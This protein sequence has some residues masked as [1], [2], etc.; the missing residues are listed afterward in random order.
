[1][2]KKY[3]SQKDI[4]NFVYPNHTLSEYDI[5]L[6]QDI[7][8]N[9]VYGS[10]SSFNAY[11]SGGN[12]VISF[13]YQW[14]L[15]NAEPFI[16]GNGQ[17][18]ILSVHMMAPNTTYFKPWRLVDFVQTT[19]VNTTTKTGTF[20]ATVTPGQFQV[21]SLNEGV[22][23]FEIRMI[24]HRA[25]YPICVSQSVVNVTPTPTPSQVAQYPC[26]CYDI[27]VTGTTLGE[28]QAIASIS[29][30]NCYGVL[31]T[32]SYTIGPATYQL[33]IERLGG[34]IQ[35]FSASGIDESYITGVGNGACVAG[36]CPTTGVTST[37]TPT[38]T[39][40]PTVTHTPGLSPTPT[41]TVTSS[42]SLNFYPLTLR[43]V[44][45]D[46]RTGSLTVYQSSDN[47]TFEQSAQIIVSGNTTTNQ[48]FNGTP[49]YYYYFVVAKT[50]GPAA[51]L[52]AYVDAIPDLTPSVDGAWCDDAT[53]L[54][55]DVFQLP[56]PA[57]STTSF[58][59]YGSVTS[60]GCL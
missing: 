27:A 58:I 8:D 3:I 21:G 51:T 5:E 42:P 56:N 4:Q 60:G 38:P 34:V 16:G 59:W 6:I 47:I 18:N 22:Y 10:I 14:H 41:P 45:S 32:T 49:G 13:N 39:I 54:T 1:M 7:K 28:G 43:L 33:C 9:S 55:T 12:I 15:N 20:T 19:N 53:T 30:N 52:N 36:V 48:G 2:S 24:G 50:S 57:Q 35:Y 37:P 26:Y 23:N 40:T 44:G 31:T 29:Y 46:G 11:L 25:I 17:L